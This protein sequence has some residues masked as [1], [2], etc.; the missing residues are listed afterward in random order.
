MN[1][2]TLFLL[3]AAPGLLLAHP[4]G[5][6]SVNHYA[7]LQVTATGVQLDYVLDLAEIPSF[8]L[9]HSWNL[10]SASPRSDLNAQAIRQARQWLGNVK[11][12][13]NGK[14]LPIHLRSADLFLADGAANLPVMRITAHA[15]AQAKGGDLSYEDLNY[16]DRTGW[17]EIVIA[18]ASGAALER[19]SHTDRDI[20][21]ALT[22]YPPDPT[23]AP[24]QDLRARLV[25]R[26]VPI[27]SRKTQPIPAAT[28]AEARSVAISPVEQPH[29]APPAVSPA[30]L[31]PQ[32]AR[33]GTVVRGDFLS[34]L[35]HNARLTPWMLLLALAVAFGLGA[36][37]A[38]TPGHGKTIV[39]AYLIC[40]RGTMKHAAFL[41]AMVTFTH[42]ISVFVLGI[43]TLFLFQWVVPEKIAQV[44]GVVSGISI[45]CIGG[46]ML[47]RRL[48][49]WRRGHS[50]SH[51]HAHSHDHDH[52]HHH[53]HHDHNHGGHT[54]A[55][56]HSHEHAAD[57][58]HVHSHVPDKLSWAALI[59]LGISGGLV[60]CES[61][62]ILML[63]AIAL[64]R[65]AFGLLL[66]VA[67]SLG[68]AIVLVA[69]GVLVVYAKHLLPKSSGSRTGVA[70]RWLSA[71]SAAVVIIIGLLM[72]GVSAGILQSR[73]IAY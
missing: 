8:E 18:Q 22:A 58:S 33:P 15:S 59:A 48:P 54:H 42:T 23:L 57:V 10:Q 63:S 24:P 9:L 44:C 47:Y 62:L 40:S 16:P 14:P 71:A 68:L 28:H 67:F 12:S 31:N 51:S 11:V 19:A 20:S 36:M 34:R 64:G 35:L 69:I 2:A 72:T 32:S 39:A 6:F 4:M 49:R 5:N 13:L 45:V 56:S 50:D 27:V 61:A 46:W 53:H 3:L 29:Q 17:K 66:L 25:W 52:D 26:P 65:A 43:A 21:K 60:P 55:H 41:G 30:A 1:R 7:R 38:L 37:H 73:W 70:V